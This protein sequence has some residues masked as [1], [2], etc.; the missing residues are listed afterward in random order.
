MC[1]NNLHK[2]VSCYLI[3]LRAQVDLACYHYTSK[4]HDIK[5]VHDKL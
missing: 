1:V 2:I 4:S 5:V 3:V